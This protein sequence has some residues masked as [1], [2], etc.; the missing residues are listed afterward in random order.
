MSARHVKQKVVWFSI[1]ILRSITG[2][3]IW[4]QKDWHKPHGLTNL[5]H[6]INSKATRPKGL[7]MMPSLSL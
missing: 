3:A 2:K 5:G 7:R 6:K 4:H 1:F